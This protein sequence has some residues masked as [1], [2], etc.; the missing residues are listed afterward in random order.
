MAKLTSLAS[1][2][3]ALEAPET[4]VYKESKFKASFLYDQNEATAIDR[5]THFTIC[6][7]GF[8]QLCTINADFKEF[9]ESLFSLSSKKLDRALL[10]K[11]ASEKLDKIIKNYLF[12]VVTPYFMLSATH[13]TLEWLIYR[14]QI[15]EY[16][17]V[18]L[19]LSVLPYHETKLFPKVVRLISKIRD[20]QHKWHWLRD[21]RRHQVPLPKASLITHCR[22]HPSTLRSIVD[23]ILDVVR[24]GYQNNVLTSFFTATIISIGEQDFDEDLI[25]LIMYYLTKAFR[26]H[27]SSLIASGFVILGH[28][29]TRVLLNPSKI[30]KVLSKMAKHVE[31][32]QSYEKF[33]KDYF[34]TL[35]VVFEFQDL[36]Q[37]N[38]NIA[39]LINTDLI[40]EMFEKFSSKCFLGSLLSYYIERCDNDQF[41]VKAMSLINNLPLQS[42][43]ITKCLRSVSLKFN[44]D[45]DQQTKERLKDIVKRFERIFPEE[46]DRA[47]SDPSLASED[48]LIVSSFYARLDEENINV[49]DGLLHSSKRVRL[50]CAMH[51]AKHYKK[52][53]KSNEDYFKERICST[54]TNTWAESNSAVLIEL[55]SSKELFIKMISFN[56]L[57]QYTK[58]LLPRCIEMVE[59]EEKRENVEAGN[60]WRTVQKLCLDLVVN[61]EFDDEIQFWDLFLDY[62]LPV[63]G[64]GLSIF[65]I[66]FGNPDSF[67][68]KFFR[69]LKIELTKDLEKAIAKKD[70]GA[71]IDLFSDK[72]ANYITKNSQSSLLEL[73]C[74]AE[75]SN[76]KR[77]ILTLCVLYHGIDKVPDFTIFNKFSLRLVQILKIILEG[78]RIKKA[79]IQVSNI[80]EFINSHL[81]Q[82]RRHHCT[83]EMI[84]MFL[85]KIISSSILPKTKD[86]WYWSKQNV[87]ENYLLKILNFLSIYCQKHMSLR[88]LMASFLR[89]SSSMLVEILSGLWSNDDALLQYRGLMIATNCLNNRKIGDS[90]MLILLTLLTSPHSSIRSQ[91]CK[92]FEVINCD[93][94]LIAILKDNSNELEID[95][96]TV[97]V[98][99][100]G[101][102]TPKVYNLIKNSV[103]DPQASISTR[104]KL[105]H[106]LSELD[107]ENCLSVHLS[108]ASELTDKEILTSEETEVMLLVG[109]KIMKMIPNLSTPSEVDKLD[110]TLNFILRSDYLRVKTLSCIKSGY[111][112][113]LTTD[114]SKI[115]LIKTLLD[116]IILQADKTSTRKLKKLL[117]DGNIVCQVIDLLT[118][119][120]AP[121]VSTST[122]SLTTRAKRRKI[123]LAKPERIELSLDQV[124]WRKVVLLLE[125]FKSQEKFKNCN[126]IMK[127]AFDLL[128]KTLVSEEKCS[129]EYFRLLLLVTISLCINQE[130]VDLKDFELQYIFEILRHARLRETQMQ[131]I[132]IILKLSKPLENE[133]LHDLMTIFGFMGSNMIKCDD[134]YAQKVLDNTMDAII[135]NLKQDDLDAQH[136]IIEIFTD[137]TNDIPAHRRLDLFHKLAS[138]LDADKCLWFIAFRLI[139]RIVYD[140]SQKKL[141]SDFVRVLV[142]TF[143]G[144]TQL[145]T[146]IHLV[147]MTLDI[148]NSGFFTAFNSTVRFN[149]TEQKSLLSE[150]AEAVLSIVSCS[151]FIAAIAE[152]KWSDVDKLFQEF[153]EVNLI[154]VDNLVQV[155]GKAKSH[156][157]KQLTRILLKILEKVDYTIISCRFMNFVLS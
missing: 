13:K 48:G 44:M 85:S 72:I 149:E 10:S 115:Y 73:L 113:L 43:V 51:I 121:N 45:C 94:P 28:L 11:S 98:L 29:S 40:T 111:V 63:E 88:P 7:N 8:R 33:E 32:S 20:P 108:V 5:E 89:K 2:L 144:K 41:F 148:K 79:S 15:H 37:M 75:S 103:T 62:F 104:L 106:L 50:Y 136:K 27:D 151:E 36:E 30:D 132:D 114:T 109:S 3:K 135:T 87:E 6:L 53:L 71:S 18:H 80:S 156:T 142:C 1:Q 12:R 126:N 67:G 97:A 76:F 83:E 86:R 22:T 14:F 145:I 92:L 120:G 93:C 122:E 84:E 154:L 26:S 42:W 125:V 58:R 19:L 107:T 146:L 95:C 155:S 59:K 129:F 147:K 110:N 139:Q 102:Q 128:K 105:L 47:I 66:L 137:A 78:C 153:L 64:A 82:L 138:L 116:F 49:F 65:T 35:L 34:L 52:I 150:T 70:F 38:E 133:I 24:D 118:S 127:M 4:N 91:T 90:E 130:D 21:V 99:V 16:N 141:L 134:Q 96:H 55:L 119:K 124:E 46:F 9:E 140:S 143:D 17:S 157:Y 74:S 68:S 123:E 31:K 112:K 131:A 101:H 23:I 54:L 152:S 57:I 81:K 25:A 69:T 39:S 61:H 117:E 56:D 77:N 60:D 100:A